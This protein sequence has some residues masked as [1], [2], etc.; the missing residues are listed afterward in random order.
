MVS[1]N[2]IE[3]L[4]EICDLV[5]GDARK[6]LEEL[7]N[8]QSSFRVAGFGPQKIGALEEWLTANGYLDE[9]QPAQA[10]ELIDAMIHAGPLEPDQASELH[11]WLNAAI[12]A[13]HN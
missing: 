7:R 2:Y 3:A 9:P 5:D 8:K 12:M 10:F 4:A 13:K 1:K 11:G 6:L